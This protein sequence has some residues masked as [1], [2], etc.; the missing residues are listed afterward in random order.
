MEE[1]LE[2]AETL[3][4]QMR[5][6]L[7]PNLR[8]SRSA[9]ILPGLPSASPASSSGSA[10][11]LTLDFATRPGSEM[12]TAAS[13]RRTGRGEGCGGPDSQ[14]IPLESPPATDD[15]DWDEQESMCQASPPREDG[16]GGG[17]EEGAPILDGMASLTVDEK[18]AGYLGVASG[19]ALLRILEPSRASGRRRTA[20]S[21]PSSP[22]SPSS[23]SAA[24]VA[25]VAGCLLAQPNVRRHVADAMVDAYFRTYHVSYPILHEPTFR[26]QYSEVI[27]RPHG[28]SWL[29]LAYVV[30]AL[31]VFSTA[32]GLD[33]T[34][35]ALFAQARSI[36]SFKYLEMGNLT[37][38]QSLS[39]ISNYQQKRDKPNSGYSYLGLA[40]RMAMGLGLHKEFQ[41]WTSISPLNME[42]RRRVWWTLCAFEVGATITF[43]RP[44]VWPLA[45]VEVALPMNVYDGE[46][47]VASAGYPRESAGLTPYTPVR[48]QASFH[49]ATAGIYRRVIS[50]PFP[51]VAELARLEDELYAPWVRSLPPC[52]REGATVPPRYV[53]AH[54]VMQWRS[55]HFRIIMVGV[56][57]FFFFFFIVF[58]FAP[59]ILLSARSVVAHAVPALLYSIAPSSSGAPSTPARDARPSRR[60][61]PR[62]SPP[63]SGAW[64]MPSSPSSP[65]AST[66]RG[67]ST[68]GWGRGMPCTSSS[69]PP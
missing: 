4:R 63:S 56:F 17:D 46:L 33:E 42:I 65:S 69:R 53:F 12:S 58:V 28:D 10:S 36:L 55:R 62:A 6:F 66:G 16:S 45:G 13:A 60:R 2:R 50:K 38:V 47:T 9:A 39:L 18:E 11:T 30:A 25:S 64:P 29:V 19:A 51:D 32:T 34:D 43:S 21:D 61:R 68:T 8:A 26:A 67:T 22:S 15:F 44:L 3:L 41:N 5:Q 48:A 37:L 31:G 40:T 35:V 59:L 49:V 1:K 24:A 7:P 20:R 57:F 52:F 14:A 54:A 27:G 23:S